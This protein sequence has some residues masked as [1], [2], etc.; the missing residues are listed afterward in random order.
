MTIFK[1]ATAA[2]IALTSLSLPAAPAIAQHHEGDRWHRDD[3]G[4]H[5]GWRNHRRHRHQ[6]C[7]WRWR[8][9]HRVRICYTVWR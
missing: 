6:V 2:A 4:R 8:H 1:F 5:N 7:N 9:H 3:N